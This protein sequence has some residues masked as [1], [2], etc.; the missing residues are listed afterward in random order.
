MARL[1]TL[2]NVTILDNLDRLKKICRT[3]LGILPHNIRVLR[4]S[5][6]RRSDAEQF[7]FQ[8]LNDPKMTV[9]N[10]GRALLPWTHSLQRLELQNCH[11][12]TTSGNT[13]LSSTGFLARFPHLTSLELMII[14]IKNL[15]RLDLS[16]C[17]ALQTLDCS[18]CDLL[19]LDVTPCTAL[20][21]LICSKNKL[22]DLD[23][24][25]CLGLKNL[26]CDANRMT[27]TLDLAANTGL[28]KLTCLCNKLTTIVLSPNAAVHTLKCFLNSAQ[29][30]LSG[31]TKILH[32]ACDAH[33]GL[34]LQAG[35]LASLHALSLEDGY[36]DGE[37]TGFRDLKSLSCTATS[38][39]ALDFH[40]CSGV[41]VDCTCYN[42]GV[43]ITGREGVKKL[44]LA[45]REPIGQWMGFNNLEEVRYTVVG[46]YAAD[47][48]PCSML[49]RVSI[50]NSSSDSVLGSVSLTG[51]S[52]FEELEIDGYD[53][54]T[55][56]GVVG[57]TQ[58][59][60]LSCCG[61]SVRS[62]DVSSCPLLESLD[63][64][65]SKNLKEIIVT[66][67]TMLT[68]ITCDNCTGFD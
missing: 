36:V 56:L 15:P 59:K 13:D 9:Q 31:G 63:V 19:R 32:L 5:S 21:S 6:G 58:L 43:H 55:H 11:L 30:M 14:S 48:S 67:C 10:L 25:A 24:S 28:Q 51:C 42:G 26:D 62:F 27:K 37:L 18:V 52:C 16:G 53:S 3:D 38:G 50:K 41:E 39:A 60:D 45:V 17:T 35:I 8:S 68:S 44:T 54:L 29:L 4:L 33:T 7:H 40:A 23:L 34:N 12:R 66:G 2:D 20:S 57:C 1:P 61:S 65:G 46:Q 64:S 22:D 47:L 49:K